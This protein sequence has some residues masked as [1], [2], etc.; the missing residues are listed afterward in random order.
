MRQSWAN[1]DF[2]ITYAAR[3]NFAFDSIF[4]KKLDPLFF[5]SFTVAEEHRW[6]QRIGLLSEEERQCME[7]VV[8]QKLEQMQKRALAW[9]PGEVYT[10]EA[11]RPVI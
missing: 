3:K 1:G 11:C 8:S 4:W 7:Q 9:E 2:W 5:G 10:F 6:E